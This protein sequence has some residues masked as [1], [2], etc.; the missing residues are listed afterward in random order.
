MSEFQ[1]AH[2]VATLK[3]S[4]PGYIGYGDGGVLTEAVRRS[5]YSVVL[6]DEAE[7]AHDALE[8]FYQVFDQGRME[9]SEGREIDFRNP[10]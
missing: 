5:P 1:E 10:V 9:D 8:L 2:S 6:L 4:P 7:K 3:G